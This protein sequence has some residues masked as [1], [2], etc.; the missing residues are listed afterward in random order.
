MFVL[1]PRKKLNAS[2][3]KQTNATLWVA[4]LSEGEERRTVDLCSLELRRTHESD[5]TKESMLGKLLPLISGSKN[6][7][8]YGLISRFGRESELDAYVLSPRTLFPGPTPRDDYPAI[9]ESR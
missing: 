8:Y 3:F 5:W 2:K 6:E 7:K 9:I 1:L 4:V